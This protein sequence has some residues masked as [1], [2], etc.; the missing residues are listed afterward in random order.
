MGDFRESRPE[1]RKNMFF[2]GPFF[3][4]PFLLLLPLP[5]HYRGGFSSSVSF[6]FC[7]LFLG[8]GN[9][10]RRTFSTSP[11][12]F[13]APNA[14]PPTKSPRGASLVNFGN[15][16]SSD[17]KPSSPTYSTYSFSRMHTQPP[18]PPHSSPLAA[19]FYTLSLSPTKGRIPTGGGGG[20]GEGG[21]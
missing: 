5:T 17:G 1:E 6:V 13:G 10:G 7:A 11:Y 16:Y 8:G 14:F 18:F 3:S 15:P 9:G 19:G 2:P 12:E 20:G 4:F 21:D